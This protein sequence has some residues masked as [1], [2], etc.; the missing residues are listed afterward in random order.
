MEFTLTDTQI[1]LL[2][3]M[4]DNADLRLAA[5][6]A[7]PRT[8]AEAV[9]G[10]ANVVFIQADGTAIAYERTRAPGQR[11]YMRRDIMGAPPI[12]DTELDRCVRTAA[13]RAVR[14]V[15]TLPAGQYGSDRREI[16]RESTDH[17]WDMAA[18]VWV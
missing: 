15:I 18:W 16:R 9:R 6:L 8:A 10:S 1:T 5:E 11:S 14:V 2:S 7:L 4:Q 12:S 13:D 17:A 3:A